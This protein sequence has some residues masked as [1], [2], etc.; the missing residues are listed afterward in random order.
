MG[1]DCAVQAFSFQWNTIVMFFSWR[2]CRI[3]W[4]CVSQW[5]RSSCCSEKV[6]GNQFVASWKLLFVRITTWLSENYQHK[7]I[8][9]Q[10]CKHV[11]LVGGCWTSENAK[12]FNKN[13]NYCTT[14]CSS[15]GQQLS[16]ARRARALPVGLE[17]STSS[18]RFF[19]IHLP[20]LS[21]SPLL[22]W[23]SW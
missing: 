3:L 22:M 15:S 13:E 6:C 14:I 10:S 8:E 1:R 2:C 5:R 4:R 20:L 12:K 23:S 19:A 7:S 21:S 11:N 9:L 17:T 16:S 18:S